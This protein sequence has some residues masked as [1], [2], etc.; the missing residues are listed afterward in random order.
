MK[1]Q[2]KNK[3]KGFT[4]VELIVVVVILGIL[5]AIAVPK[6]TGKQEDAKVKADI[7]SARTIVS[8]VA[9]AQSEGTATMATAQQPTVAELVTGGYLN[10]EPKSAQN[11]TA[12]VITYD[13]KNNVEKITV[14]G[15]KTETVYPAP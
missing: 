6:L 8:A 14:T 10:A 1:K 13:S 3:K 9:L 11:G 15:A 7:A 2:L 12:F 4:L 5:A